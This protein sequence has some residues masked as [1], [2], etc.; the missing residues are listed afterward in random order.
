MPTPIPDLRPFFVMLPDMPSQTEVWSWSDVFGNA[1]PVE[2]EIGS[3]RGLFI[4]NAAQTHPERN[5]L[6]IE[7]DLKEG[8]RA[9]KRLQKRNLLN[10]K[11]L[12]HDARYVV[13]KMI[14]TGSVSAVHIYFPDPWWKRRHR[15]R[16]IF[17]PDVISEVV[18]MLQPGGVLHAWTDVEEYFD[19]MRDVAAEFP[20]LSPLPPPEERA[21]IHDMDYQTSFERKKRQLGLPIYRARWERLPG[22]WQPRIISIEEQ[23]EMDEADAADNNDDESGAGL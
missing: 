8:R 14:A 22:S 20:L 9:S 10:A 11:I 4:M 13:S 12:G 17:A 21:P 23:R 1:H 6:G 7:Y 2:V 5:F 19:V 18:R 15:K 16:R 3:G